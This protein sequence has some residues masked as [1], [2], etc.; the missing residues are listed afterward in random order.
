M[1]NKLKDINNEIKV[2]INESKFVSNKCRNKLIKELGN[3]FGIKLPVENFLNIDVV[4]TEEGNIIMRGD[5]Y[6]TSLEFKNFSEVEEK[7]NQFKI[8]A[9]KIINNKNVNYY[10]KQDKNNILNLFIIL[11]IIIIF[12]ILLII[13]IKSFLNGNY[14]NTLWLIMF[15]SSWLVPKLGIGDRFIQAKNY[16]TRRFKK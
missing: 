8:K 11:L 14:F 4:L 16:L 9:D 5:L 15:V 13:A 7:Y 3:T 2:Y 1:N 10:N 6:N 12:F